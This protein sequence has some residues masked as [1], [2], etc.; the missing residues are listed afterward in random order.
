M[1]TK[2]Y[3][4]FDAASASEWIRVY[5]QI[6]WTNDSMINLQRNTHLTSYF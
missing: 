2:Y 5:K 6:H 1:V 3:V 4:N